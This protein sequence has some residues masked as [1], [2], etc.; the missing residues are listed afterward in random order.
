M[1]S[2][3]ANNKS[4][5]FAPVLSPDGAMLLKLHLREEEKFSPI[6]QRLTSII[7]DPDTVNAIYIAWEA[8]R[9]RIGSSI[10]GLS[11]DLDDESYHYLSRSK[12]RLEGDSISLAAFLRF[13]MLFNN[14]FASY[15]CI[16]ATGAIRKNPFGYS[17]DRV[18]GIREKLE[19]TCLIKNTHQKTAIV[20]PKVNVKELDIENS[21]NDIWTANQSLDFHCQHIAN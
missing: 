16:V 9:V 20:L 5:V 18:E 13:Y 2:G 3:S 7:T 6:S 4:V 12:L 17:I 15:Q 21:V 8:I 1:I 11:I 14:Q 10:N 19:K